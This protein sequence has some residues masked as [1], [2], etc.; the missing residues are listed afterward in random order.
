MQLL[1]PTSVADVGCGTGAWLSVFHEA[2]VEDILGID[3]D[4]IDRSL[5]QVPLDRFVPRDLRLPLDI[6]RTF[7]LVVS[8]E[9]AEHLPADCAD[10][11]VD[12]LVGLGPAILFSAAIPNQ[13]G[14]NHINER[15]QSYWVT[16]FEERGYACVDLIRPRIWDDERVNWWYRQ[17]TFLF[18]DPGLLEMNGPWKQMS[19]KAAWPRSIV[20]PML[21][22]TA[23]LRLEAA[24]R[25]RVHLLT[26]RLREVLPERVKVVLR[27]S[28]EQIK[29]PL[30]KLRGGKHQ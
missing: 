24:S 30:S 19:D 5:L 16:L 14:H 11:F 12:S 25:P 7:D 15:W 3:G 28:R 17:N 4:Y 21:L 20:H 13:G 6:D 29:G 22:E 9:V 2:G 23:A 1:Q 26:D 10:R 18:V 27:A 8:L